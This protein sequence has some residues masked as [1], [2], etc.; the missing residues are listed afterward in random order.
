MRVMVFWN[1]LEQ[2]FHSTAAIFGSLWMLGILSILLRLLSLALNKGIAIDLQ[3]CALNKG[4]LQQEFLGLAQGPTDMGKA[5]AQL[6]RPAGFHQRALQEKK[7]KGK[8][9]EEKAGQKAKAHLKRLAAQEEKEEEEAAMSLEDKIA[10]L[11]KKGNQ[12]M[13]KWLDTLTKGQREAL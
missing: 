9:E 1:S 7:E 2:I 4:L 11:Q 13:G 12:D 6:T 10:L 5:K 8:K 3:W